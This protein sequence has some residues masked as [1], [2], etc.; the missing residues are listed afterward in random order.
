MKP[1]YLQAVLIDKKVDLSD[2]I[3][4]FNNI[5]KNQHKKTF[6]YREEGDHYRFRNIPKIY[7]D[8][9]SFKTKKVNDEVSL[10]FGHLVDE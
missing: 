4:T 3:H 1:L 9:N 5:T 10:I 8:K 7:F 6:F 2:A